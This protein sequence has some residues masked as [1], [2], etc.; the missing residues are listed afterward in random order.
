MNIYSEY[1]IVRMAVYVN[2]L[3]KLN[4]IW[5]KN[6]RYVKETCIDASGLT[7]SYVIIRRRKTRR[8][9]KQTDKYIEE[10]KFIYSPA[11]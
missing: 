1:A 11:K 2:D 7:E 5:W 6:R 8:V 3:C 10:I 9:K 4:N